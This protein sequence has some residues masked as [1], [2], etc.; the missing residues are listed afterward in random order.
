[1]RVGW[2]EIKMPPLEPSRKEEGKK[3]GARVKRTRIQKLTVTFAKRQ[4]AG[5]NRKEKASTR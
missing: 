1:V 3:G 2:D 5:V 4:Q